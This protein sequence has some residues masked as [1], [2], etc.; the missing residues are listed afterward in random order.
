VTEYDQMEAR[1][2]MLEASHATAK[3]CAD[4]LGMATAAARTAADDLEAQLE[5]LCREMRDEERREPMSITTLCMRTIG[6]PCQ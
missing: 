5:K 4:E 3:R 6:R 2:R 1:R